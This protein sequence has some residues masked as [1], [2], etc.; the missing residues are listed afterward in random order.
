M[1]YEPTTWKS[2]D[3]VTSAKLNKIESGIVGAEP[4][5]V[6][7]TAY[8]EDG[9]TGLRL[10]A[11][12]KEIHDAVTAHKLVIINKT[13]DG[14]GFDYFADSMLVLRTWVYKNETDYWVTALGVSLEAT[15]KSAIY[16]F[17]ADGENSYP[18]SSW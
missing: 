8:S 1:A 6:T 2:G 18:V 14:S 4:V 15:D 17:A 3:V 13:L 9:N 10:S 7:A 5:A 11:T 16:N 12:W